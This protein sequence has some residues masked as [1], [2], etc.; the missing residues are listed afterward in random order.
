MY[1]FINKKAQKEQGIVHL[2]NMVGNEEFK[3]LKNLM[4]LQK[5]NTTEKE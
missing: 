2:S 5:D 4:N 1:N 3:A